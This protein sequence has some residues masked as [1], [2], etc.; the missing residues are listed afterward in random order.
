MKTPS[1]WQTE[2]MVFAPIS[3]TDPYAGEKITYNRDSPIATV[4]PCWQ[5][6]EGELTQSEYA[7]EEKRSFRAVLYP[8]AYTPKEND[9]FLI[10][11]K[12]FRCRKV[13]AYKRHFEIEVILHE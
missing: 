9:G 4:Y 5:P 13:L 11:G 3:A 1:S 10:H 8:G 2:T 12:I 7:V 6:A